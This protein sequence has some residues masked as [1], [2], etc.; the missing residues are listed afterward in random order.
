MNGSKYC[1]TFRTIPLSSNIFLHSVKS[2]NISIS[3]YSIKH[4][5]FAFIQFKCQTV[6]FHPWIVPYLVQPLRTRVDLGAMGMKEYSA[7]LKAPVMI[8]SSHS[9]CLM[10]YHGH[11][12]AGA[13][14]SAKRQSVYSTASN[15]WVSS[16]WHYITSN[17]KASI[18]FVWVL[19]YI[20]Y[21]RLFNVYTFL[22][23]IILFQTILLA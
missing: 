17:D 8:G 18:L 7:L 20:N 5:S 11:S 14:P 2:S 21:Y 3:N 13:Y 10:S 19:W 22:F 4:K 23:Q 9:D 1:N 15:D 16:V 12:L 6:I